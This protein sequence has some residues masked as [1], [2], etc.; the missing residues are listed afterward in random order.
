MRRSQAFLRTF[1][2]EIAFTRE[3]REGKRIIKITS[4]MDFSST[5]PSAPSAS[6]GM[7]EPILREVQ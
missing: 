2:I 4:R 5:V 3:G 6:P 7:A 1:G